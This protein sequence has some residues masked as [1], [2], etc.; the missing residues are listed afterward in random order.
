MLHLT[1]LYS[2]KVFILWKRKLSED[3]Q[4]EIFKNYIHWY[5]ICNFIHLYTDNTPTLVPLE[6]KWLI[7]GTLQ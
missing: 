2:Q 6:Q 7:K 4:K 3:N 1:D 5:M